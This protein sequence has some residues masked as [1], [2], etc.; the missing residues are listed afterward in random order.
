M[1]KLG[2]HTFQSFNLR[3][4]AKLLPFYEL[5][6]STTVE[7][8]GPIELVSNCVARLYHGPDNDSDATDGDD[9]SGALCVL[10]KGIRL[11]APFLS[12][13]SD[14]LPINSNGASR[15]SDFITSTS[16]VV[17]NLLHNFHLQCGAPV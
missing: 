12:N 7:I 1:S 11:A 14:D 10:M 13:G 5:V 8:L 3:G 17:V 2:N 4:N 6:A 9:I 16:D 15:N